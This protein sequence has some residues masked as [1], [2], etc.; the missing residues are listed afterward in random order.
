MKT[1]IIYDKAGVILY[2]TTGINN[3]IPEGVPYLEVE[4][5]EIPVG[6][7]LKSIDISVIPNVPIYAEVQI[8]QNGIIQQKL[9]E[10]QQQLADIAYTLMIGGL[11]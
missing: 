2:T 11:V 4:E 7:T 9:A 10:T 6:K 1:L 5:S 8:T 3:Y